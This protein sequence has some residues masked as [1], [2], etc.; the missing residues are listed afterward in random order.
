M[1]RRKTTSEFIQEAQSVH[2]K[3]YDYSRVEYINGREKVLII[4][5][6]PAHSLSDAFNQKFNNNE[7]LVTGFDNL[8]CMEYDNQEG[9]NQYHQ[10]LKQKMILTVT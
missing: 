2:N 1:G 9:I 5:T 3:L 8:Y 10:E 6:D 7:C 4:S